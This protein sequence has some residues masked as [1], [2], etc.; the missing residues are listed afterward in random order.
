MI[1]IHC[2]LLPG[3]DDGAQSLEQS[4][5]LVKKAVENGIS[6]AV[7]TPHIH[8]GR[9][10]NN[11]KSIKETYQ[12]LKNIIIEQDIPL[13]LGFAAEVHISPEVK[14]LVARQEMPFYG[15]YENKNIML[16]ELPTSHIPPG[17]EK[18]IQWL[19]DHNVRPMIAHPERN[20]SIAN[21]LDKLSP[22]IEMNCLL[23]ITAASVAGLFGQRAEQ[24]SIKMLEKDL[25]DVIASDAHNIAYRPPRLDHG[26]DAAA[27]ILG[28]EKAAKL[29]TETPMS[30]C[31]S[32]F[33][34]NES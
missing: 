8:P 17:T 11:L 29:V 7:A 6:H 31:A 10:E 1:D 4:L 12:N 2:H 21:D 28:K 25:V 20:K 34:E 16:L 9:F 14:A 15:V 3:I 24:T 19:L 26:R 32:Q 22:F 33:K 30:I 18:L 5:L 13:T 27:K 23:Q